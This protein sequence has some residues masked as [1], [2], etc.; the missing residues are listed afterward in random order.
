M[1]IDKI[2]NT[3]VCKACGNGIQEAEIEHKASW[4]NA[5][6]IIASCGCGQKYQAV[7]HPDEFEA[8]E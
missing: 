1:K 4:P 3:V 6:I 5:I 7:A 8:I 2:N